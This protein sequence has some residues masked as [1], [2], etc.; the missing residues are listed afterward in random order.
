MPVPVRRRSALRPAATVWALSD[1][2]REF[3]DALARMPRS[4][5]HRKKRPP[6]LHLAREINA[7][8]DTP[9][10]DVGEDQVL[11]SV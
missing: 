7:L 11:A 5:D 6:H 4:E 10:T 1:S 8:H 3:A 9:K 2:G